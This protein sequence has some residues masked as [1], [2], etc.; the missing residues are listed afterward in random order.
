M[1]YGQGLHGCVNWFEQDLMYKIS[2]KSGL[3][4]NYNNLSVLCNFDDNP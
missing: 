1:F 2:A 3:Q 4:I